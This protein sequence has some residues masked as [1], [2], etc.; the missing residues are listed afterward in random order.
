M[1]WD[2][3]DGTLGLPLD[4][5]NKVKSAVKDFV[6]KKFVSRR[7]LE[8]VVGF[9]NFACTVDPKGRVYLKPVNTHMRK[10]ANAKLTDKLFPLSVPLKVSLR[11]WLKPDVLSRTVPWTIPEPHVEV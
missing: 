10:V 9:I 11:W 4:Y 1:I 5:Q 2:T 8:R 6:A 7:Q 3:T